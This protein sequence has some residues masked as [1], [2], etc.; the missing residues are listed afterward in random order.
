MI[1]WFHLPVVFALAVR[2]VAGLEVVVAERV[3]PTAD[4]VNV[5]EVV[6]VFFGTVDVIPALN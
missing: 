5:L 3:V 1:K 6:G 2:A 4:F